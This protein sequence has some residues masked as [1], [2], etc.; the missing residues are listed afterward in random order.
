MKELHFEDYADLY[1]YMHEIASDG[2]SITI[3]SFNYDV[4]DIL[5][6]FLQ[7]EDVDIG[8]VKIDENYDDEYYITLDEF[9]FLNIKPVK[10]EN[11][12]I[13]IENT[14]KMLFDGDI[15][16]SI[17]LHNTNC[18]QYEICYQEN[19]DICGECC[20]DCTNCNHKETV[21]VLKM[22]FDYLEYLINHGEDWLFGY[23]NG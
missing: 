9:L 17:A 11:G 1:D 23:P 19:D 7:Y 21:E 8:N 20:E 5:R 14:D 16:S 4:V 12:K 15:P 13:V 2:E 22:A 3:I 6:W 10:D 18:E